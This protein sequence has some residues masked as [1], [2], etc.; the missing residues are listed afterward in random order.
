MD[1]QSGMKRD[2]IENPI[3][4]DMIE[5]Y[6]ETT[7]VLWE[8]RGV[9]KDNITIRIW[10]EKEVVEKVFSKTEWTEVLINSVIKGRVQIKVIPNL[11]KMHE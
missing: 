11:R 5:V 3:P 6:E 7:W 1:Q 9:G 2:Q 10:H 4:G 8:V